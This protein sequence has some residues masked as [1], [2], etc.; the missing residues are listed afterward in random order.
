[1]QVAR[2][3]QCG[4]LT[5]ANGRGDFSAFLMLKRCIQ[6]DP[7]LRFDVIVLGHTRSAKTSLV[8]SILT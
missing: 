1:M 8:R 3:L 6:S 4:A 7:N 5:I 2:M